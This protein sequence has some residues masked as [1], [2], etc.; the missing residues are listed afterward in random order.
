LIFGQEPVL[1]KTILITGSSRG[2]GRATALLAAKRGYDVCVHYNTNKTAADEV[3][4][5]IVQGG[6]K[7]KALQADV[8]KEAEI[9]SLFERFDTEFGSLNALVNNAGILVS[10]ARVDEMNAKR[11]STLFT[12]NITSY[13]LCAKEAIR[14]MSSKYGGQGGAIV[15]VASAASR[16]GSAGVY[17]DYAASKAALDTFTYGLAQEVATEGIRVN[18]VRPGFIAT[19]MHAMTGLP[20]RAAE[21][22]KTVPMQRNGTAEEVAGAILWLLSDEASYT[23]GAHLDISGAR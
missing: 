9:L 8:S 3:V 22:A 10:A 16:T 20:N 2:I 4:A 1:Q 7:A 13:F 11:L 12:T 18:A 19:D 15:N 5:T 14:R 23:S 21:V 6:G 17:V